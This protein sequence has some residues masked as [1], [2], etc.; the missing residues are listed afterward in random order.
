MKNNMIKKF[1]IDS[2]KDQN[3]ENLQKMLYVMF[4]TKTVRYILKLF[5]FVFNAK[6]RHCRNKKKANKSHT[7]K[8][9]Y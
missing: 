2:V 6:D 9:Y 5:I 7:R 1:S 4:F 3:H 8:I